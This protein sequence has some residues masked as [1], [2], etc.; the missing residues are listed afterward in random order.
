M[1]PE[2]LRKY[3]RNQVN[4]PPNAL[5]TGAGGLAGGTRP[6]MK[7]SLH[8]LLQCE[9]TCMLRLLPDAVTNAVDNRY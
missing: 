3:T 9:F 5:S 2:D 1:E 7:H 4:F 6:E 8:L